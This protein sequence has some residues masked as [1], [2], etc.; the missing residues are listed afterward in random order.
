F[1]VIF[2]RIL[3]REDL[4][5]R[6]DDG[7]EGGVERGGLAASGR[8][9]DEDDPVGPFDQPDETA[10]GFL[11]H[12]EL[13]QREED[14]IFVEHAHDDPLAEKHGDDA[15]AQI[16]LPAADRELDPAVLR[17]PLLRDIHVRE[18]LDAAEDRGLES[19]DLGRQLR[20]LEDAVDAIANG[21][22][23]LVRLD[24]DVARALVDRLDDDLVDE[25]DDARLLRHLEEVLRALARRSGFGLADAHHR[26]D[27]V[28]ADAVV[29][30][31]QLVD[32]RLGSEHGLDAEPGEHARLVEGVEVVGV[33][34]DDAEAAVRAG[35]GDDPAP[36]DDL[37]RQVLEG[38]GVD[39]E[40]GDLGD[41]G[42]R[43]KIADDLE[44]RRLV[45]PPCPQEDLI[46]PQSLPLL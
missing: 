30:L 20:G 41:E 3:D 5:L 17:Q 33:A 11:V 36:E 37:R 44:E 16:H 19:A 15:H 12:A 38:P 42:D 43:E 13:G 2:D 34:R 14:A 26:V 21:E 31:D 18:D 24:V 10:V 27:R 29:R 40:R 1:E 32:L 8:T 46:E 7:M 9:G 35:D 6:S 22:L 25:P 39:L 23:V 28:A 4:L 45:D